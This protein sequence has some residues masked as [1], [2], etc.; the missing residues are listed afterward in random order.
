M[1][2]CIDGWQFEATE[3]RCTSI[4][5]LE[6]SS[7]VNNKP[8]AR[9]LQVHVTGDILWGFVPLPEGQASSYTALPETYFPQLKDTSRNFKLR[10]LPYSFD[11]LVENFMDPAHIPFAH[12]SLQAKRSDGGP[13]P[14]E[15]LT[16]LRQNRTHCEVSFKDTIRNRTREGVLSFIA[17][18]Y[19]HFRT[20]S[21]TSNDF[22]LMLLALVVPTTPG[23]CRILFSVNIPVSISRFIPKWFEH[24]L[25]MRFLESDLWLHEAEIA[26]RR[27]ENAFYDSSS[28]EQAQRPRGLAGLNYKLMTTSDTACVAWRRWWNAHMLGIV[29]VVY[30]VPTGCRIT[31]NI[32]TMFIGLSRQFSE[33]ARTLLS[34]PSRSS[35]IDMRP[36]ANTARTASL[37]CSAESS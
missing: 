31:Q 10:D 9:S 33:P 2:L 5:Q 34:S 13:I 12:H 25:S 37:F 36:T 3:G 4:P 28:T 17:P 32:Y 29:T 7:R 26:A 16:D 22:K 27:S 11:F 20:R 15:I 23:Q 35:T 8:S 30:T 24:A 1:M 18:C 6:A 19:Y 21:S 14:M